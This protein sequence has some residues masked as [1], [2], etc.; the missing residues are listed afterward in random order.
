VR[1]CNCW[2]ISDWLLDSL[3]WLRAFCKDFRP[4]LLWSWLTRVSAKFFSWDLGLR[5]KYTTKVL[6]RNQL[7][8]VFVSGLIFRDCLPGVVY[9]DYATP[10]DKIPRRGITRKRW[11]Q[12][13]Q[14]QQKQFITVTAKSQARKKAL[15]KR[16]P[17]K[18]CNLKRKPNS[19]K[20]DWKRKE[21][22]KEKRKRKNEKARQTVAEKVSWSCAYLTDTI[23]KLLRYSHGIL[24]VCLTH[25]PKLVANCGKKTRNSCE[26]AWKQLTE[27]EMVL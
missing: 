14:W 13:Q 25:K 12:W 26:N 19:P 16:Q 4:E 3:A 1:C 15:T 11:Q 27:I 2:M 20:R 10:A 6:P 18:K 24:Y 21:K 7:S 22:E 8:Q 17:Q 23:F 9:C 5:Q